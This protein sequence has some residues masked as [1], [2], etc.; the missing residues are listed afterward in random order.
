MAHAVDLI[1]NFSTSNNYYYFLTGSEI[2]RVLN[3]ATFIPA[4]G[5]IVHYVAEPISAPTG[6][7]SI[8][9]VTAGIGFGRRRNLWRCITEH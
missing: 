5:R 8:A 6:V 4:V 1:D 9:G 2:I 7:G 3:T